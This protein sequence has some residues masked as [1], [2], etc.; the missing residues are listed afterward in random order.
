MFDYNTIRLAQIMT[1]ERI[2]HLHWREP[3]LVFRYGGFKWHRSL[4]SSLTN[5]LG[6]IKPKNITRLFA[7]LAPQSK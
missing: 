5:V 1:E 6:S 7:N 3:S 2:E 4:L